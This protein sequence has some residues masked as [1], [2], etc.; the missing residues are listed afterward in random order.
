[1]I[2]YRIHHINYLIFQL[3]QLFAFFV[4]SGVFIENS[5]MAWR[6]R[7]RT[8]EE[9]VS[10]LISNGLITKRTVEKA[11]R[12]VDRGNYVP[13]G[14]GSEAYADHPLGIGHGQTISAPHM[15][16]MCLE[17]LEDFV[18]RENARVLDVGSGSGYL[19]ACFGKMVG[20][21]GKVFG[22]DVLP[23]LIQWATQN[24]RKQDGSLLDQGIVSLQVGDGWKGLPEQ[25]PF[26]AIHV[27][28]AAA[29]LPNSLVEQLRPGGRLVIPVGT[30][31][32]SLIQVDKLKDGSIKEKHITGVTYVPLVKK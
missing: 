32:Q 23:E 8:N 29:T 18:T 17:L 1:M 31:S 7:G 30:H 12:S 6:S 4:Q 25:A 24:F 28:A 2:I 20:T 13:T 9:L 14:S 11:M 16:A 26:D 3:L 10:S 19:S 27:G 5:P 15:H 22:I 21:N